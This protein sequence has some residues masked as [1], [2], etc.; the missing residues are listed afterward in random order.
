MVIF[1]VI[2]DESDDDYGGVFT[3]ENPVIKVPKQCQSGKI[4]KK[5]KKRG[6]ESIPGEKA[7]SIGIS[8][9]GIPFWIC[10]CGSKKKKKRKKGKK[11]Q[12]GL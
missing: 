1:I 3:Q 6:H 9:D 2:V 7:D 12:T 10:S 11:A 5:A 8:V 4:G